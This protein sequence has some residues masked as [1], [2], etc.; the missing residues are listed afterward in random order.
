MLHFF[1]NENNFTFLYSPVNGR[2]IPLSNVN[3]SVFS[4]GMMG[5]GVAFILG[6]NTIYSP[7]DGTLSIV[8]DTLHAVGITMD[9][10]V[11]ILI[12]CGLDTVELHG[13]GFQ[14]LRAEGCR[15][16]KGEP[17]LK[18]DQTFMAKKKID[19]VTPM[20]VTDSKGFDIKILENQ[21]VFK[22]K[23]KV[24]RIQQ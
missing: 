2:Q 19:L 12:H 8:A 22:G 7:C 3:D 5:E 15:L 17:I 13:E 21:N 14:I 18:V 10:G 16:K 9:N 20:I 4:T 1:R 11:E 23:S 6:D 24:L